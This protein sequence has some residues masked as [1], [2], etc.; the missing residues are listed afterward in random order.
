MPAESTLAQ[1]GERLAASLIELQRMEREL[2][3]QR[4]VRRAEGRQ[5]VAEAVRRLAG[6]GSPAGVL[7]S[8]AGELGEGS[9]LDRVLISRVAGDRLEMVGCWC[10]GS[11]RGSQQQVEQLR[12]AAIPLGYPHVEA[13]A[14]QRRRGELVA[15]TTAESRGL[16]ELRRALGWTAYVVAPIQL[17]GEAVGLV[18]AD[19]VDPATE[20][21]S[22]DLEFALAYADGF[23]RAYERAVLR[24]KL[25]RQQ[26]QLQ[27]AA[28]W[29][30]GQSLGLGAEGSFAVGY[31]GGPEGESLDE[32]LTPRELEVIELIARGMSN[33]EIGTT[34][35]VGEGTVKYHVKNLLRKL[36]A[37]SRAEAVSAYMRMRGSA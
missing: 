36:G 24:D 9:E 18:H 28:Q 4:L 26:R 14:A 8:A 23:S 20:V 35:V 27:L 37:R 25:R 12:D 30:N 13:E 34:L 7:E 31:A 17:E 15:G 16:P 1:D 5:R 2:V 3:E 32:V 33:R 29:I 22:L 11:A 10:S 21:D 6:L 19:R